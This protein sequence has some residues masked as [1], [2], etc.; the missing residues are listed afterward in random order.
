MIWQLMKRDAT[1][2]VPTGVLVV[3]FALMAS[4]SKSLLGP[5]SRLSPETLRAIWGFVVASQ[6]WLLVSIHFIV[7]SQRDL[8]EAALPIAGRD[9]W[10]SRI[11]SLLA[12]IWLPISLAITA[13]LPLLPLLQAGA[14][15][16]VLVLGMKCFRIGVLRRPSL[17]AAA[18][19]ITLLG[20]ACTPFIAKQLKSAPLFVLPSATSVLTICGLATASLFWW[21]WTSVPK[22]FQIA[23]PG[24]GLIRLSETRDQSQF[25]WAPVFRYIYGRSTILLV[26]FLAGDIFFGLLWAASLLLALTQAQIRGRCRWLLALPIS[27]RKLFAWITIPQTAAVVV[28]CLVL[29]FVDTSHPLSTKARMVEMAAELTFVYGLTFLGEL[30]AW[31]RF[32][33]L[34]AAPLGA[35][36]LWIPLAIGVFALNFALPDTTAIQ[37]LAG[38]LPESWWQLTVILAIPVIATYWLA[39]KA[40]R[41]QEYRQLLVELPRY[42]RS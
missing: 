16:T 42:R 7:Q 4:A 21:G 12:I 14:I 37:R 26:L 32:S 19:L 27:P 17:P 22:S 33:R 3:L 18:F 34:R 1:W 11:L 35:W 24:P 15:F 36:I 23:P 20:M 28:A 40:F 10:L 41:E 38:V 6:V 13:G 5:T 25:T 8:H 31:R 2:V 9:A 29:I 39:E 30:P